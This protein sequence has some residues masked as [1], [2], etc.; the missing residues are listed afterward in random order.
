MP[1]MKASRS[2]DMNRLPIKTALIA[3]AAAIGSLM[4]QPAAVG[5]DMDRLLTGQTE[6]S[7]KVEVQAGI[8]GKLLEVDIK[9]GQRVEKDQVLAKIDDSVQ[10]ST[11]QL[12]KMEAD[13]TVNIRYVQNQLESAKN[14]YDKVKNNSSFNDTE[15]RQKL[16]EVNQAQLAVE[17][18]QEDQRE[19]QIKLEREQITLDHM[20]IR[21]PLSG[22]V[23]RVNKQAGEDTDEEPLVIIVQTQKLDAVFFPPKQLFGKI[24]EGDK[25][26]LDLEGVHRDAVVIAVDPII[27][28]DIFRVKL[29]FDNADG[30]IAA[31]S[32]VT[33]D[34]KQK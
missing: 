32:A 15:K 6:P 24:H 30:G 33:W 19:S 4:A 31:G 28:Q 22:S 5:A 11:V 23:L 18:A 14:D 3:L 20:T 21:S 25:V 10:L 8:K 26:T 16:L 13:E 1:M 34:W 29:E 2:A 12:A 17:K 7:A 27:N 9:E